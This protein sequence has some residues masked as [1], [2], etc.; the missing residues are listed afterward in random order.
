M[1]S[2]SG[3]LG[4]PMNPQL[5]GGGSYRMPGAGMM[6]APIHGTIA[7]PVMPGGGFGGFN[8][9]TAP[10]A[11]YRPIGPIGPA[12]PIQGWGGQPPQAPLSPWQPTGGMPPQVPLAPHPVAPIGP[13]QPIQ[14]PWG[15]Q[16][17]NMGQQPQNPQNFMRRPMIGGY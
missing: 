9:P 1:F 17:F 15:G 5:G 4:Q 13:A 14:G 8:P 6:P 3:L 11:P 16:Q 12:Q 2:L 7:R 10:I